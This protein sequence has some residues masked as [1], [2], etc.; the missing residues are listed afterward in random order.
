M[1]ILFAAILGFI[2]GWLINYLSDVM[3]TQRKI[4]RPMCDECETV[5]TWKDY[6]L[7]R[8]C[9]NCGH[10][11]RSW[12]TLIVLFA[13][14]TVSI[15]L[16]LYP[17]LKLGYWISLLVLTYFGIVFVIDVEHRLI[18]HIVSLAGVAIGIIAG[19]AVQSPARTLVGGLSGLLIMLGLY[20]FGTLFAR[21]RARKMG[22]DD[23]EEAL[24]F[25]D[26]ILSAVIGLM[27]GWPNITKA[28]FM[29]ILAGGTISLI[30][31]IILLATRRF[32]S[33]NIF[34]AYGPY[35]LIGA[36]ILMFFPQVASIVMGQ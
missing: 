32:Q 20:Y 17:P 23:G 9:Q 5:R 31:I 15:I 10:K 2:A 24:G 13:M 36:V 35:L 12:R 6:F 1:N 34:T 18:L 3:P 28:L 16:A 19:L 33:M 26:V 14:I 25:G 4:A 7:V 8:A 29:A 22:H 30:T 11:R 21:Y 27:V